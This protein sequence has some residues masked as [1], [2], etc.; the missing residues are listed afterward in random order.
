MVDGTGATPG[1]ELW[2]F[3]P[4]DQLASVRTNGATFDSSP[5]VGDIF[6]IGGIEAR[7]WGKHWK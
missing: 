7:P 4:N 1:S 3:L 5:A 6:V 2:A